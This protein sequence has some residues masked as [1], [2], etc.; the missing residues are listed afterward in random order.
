MQTYS[1]IALHLLYL[2][3]KLKPELHSE[4]H[5]PN[6]CARKDLSNKSLLKLIFRSLFTRWH[7]V[8]GCY[9]VA[10]LAPDPSLSCLHPMLG[11]FHFDHCK[12]AALPKAHMFPS[13]RSVLHSLLWRQAGKLSGLHQVPSEWTSKISHLLP[14]YFLK[15]QPSTHTNSFFLTFILGEKCPPLR[16]NLLKPTIYHSTRKIPS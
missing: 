8:E 11:L 4:F 2:P 14:N 16:T 3:F 1:V 13:S 7:W 15:F 5:Y 6:K 12:V 9:L 10:L